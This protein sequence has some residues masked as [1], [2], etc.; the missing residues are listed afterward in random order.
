[1]SGVV[2]LDP[3]PPGAMHTTIRRALGRAPKPYTCIGLGEI[4]GPKHC[5]FIGFGNIQGPKHY[6]FI[7]FGE[8]QGPKPYKFIRVCRLADIFYF[9]LG[10]DFFDLSSV[11]APG[12]VPHLGF[13]KQQFTRN[14]GLF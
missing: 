11:R 4:Q 9:L 6:E 7:G 1:M 10:F 14:V 5:K 13:Q 8:I 2:A 12:P 3:S